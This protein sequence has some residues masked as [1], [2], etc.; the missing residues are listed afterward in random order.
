MEEL[1]ISTGI[2]KSKKDMFFI[3]LLIYS[4]L[5]MILWHTSQ[6]LLSFLSCQSHSHKSIP[7]YPIPLGITLSWDNKW[8]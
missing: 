2:L 1:L 8:K 6:G 5:F 4:H 7:H 3:N